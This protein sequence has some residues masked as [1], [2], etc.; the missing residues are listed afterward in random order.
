GIVS[1]ALKAGLVSSNAM[2]TPPLGTTPRIRTRARRATRDPCLGSLLAG[3]PPPNV[4]PRRVLET[5]LDGPPVDVG[6]ERLD[7]LRALGRLVVE[8]E[9]VLPDVHHDEWR[10]PG[11]VADLV[12]RDPVVRQAPIDGI[13]IADRPPDATHLPDA[14]EVRLPH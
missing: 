13:L 3:R 12:Q 1:P 9:G 8:E 6:E 14:D 2:A 7:V 5:R 11:H 10:E 4:F